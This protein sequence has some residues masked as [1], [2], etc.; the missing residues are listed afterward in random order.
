[1][2]RG[3]TLDWQIFEEREWDDAVAAGLIAKPHASDHAPVQTQGG[4]REWQARLAGAFAVVLVGLLLGMLYPGWRAAGM[5]VSAA[6]AETLDHE[7]DA[8]AIPD[9]EDALGVR[10][11]MVT[12]YFR[13]EVH[14]RDSNIVGEAAASLD[15]RYH[16]LRRRLGLAAPASSL[17]IVVAAHPLVTD[18][19]REN[20]R[21]M[22][23]SPRDLPSPAAES[24]TGLLLQPLTQMALSE[25]LEETPVHWRWGLMVDGLRLWLRTCSATAS[26]TP[27]PVYQAT[28]QQVEGAAPAQHLSDLLFA[29]ADW[30]YG[31]Q[32][33]SRVEAAATLIAY[34][35]HTY[36]EE[37]VAG[38][39]HIPVDPGERKSTPCQPRRFPN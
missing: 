36:G 4:W 12:R 5:E 29:D 3:A 19:R 2:Q 30:F 27:C 23:A 16:E 14:Q 38:M 35:P 10:L 1:M 24:M 20:N 7:R 39:L 25:A 8:L 11:T 15:D 21:L 33:A 32:Q 28:A 26:D 37:K 31:A 18:W 22:I 9:A 13:F 6:P 17:T 34:I